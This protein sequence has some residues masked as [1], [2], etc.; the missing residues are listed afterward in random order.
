MG[1]MDET[2]SLAAPADVLSTGTLGR[3]YVLGGLLG[4]GGMADVYRAHDALLDRAVAV[5][6]FRHDTNIGDEHVRRQSEMQLLASLHHPG[7]VVIFDAGTDESDPAVPRSYLVM[8]L[9]DGATLGKLTAG[10]A[11]QPRDVATIGSQ[12][13]EALAYVHAR[14]IVHRDI[15][16]A[17]ILL[18]AP[19]RSDSGQVTAK[20]TDFGVARLLDGT[21]LTMHGMTVGTANYLSP[22]QATGQDVSPASDIYSFGLVLLECLTGRLAYPGYGIEAAVARL[23]R[24]PSIPEDLDPRWSQLLAK[25]TS[26]TPADRPTAIQVSSTLRE[27]VD[28]DAGS[29]DS[30]LTIVLQAAATGE[31]DPPPG[32]SR[33]RKLP[34]APSRRA[35]GRPIAS[36][37]QRQRRRRRRR[38]VLIVLAVALAVALILAVASTQIHSASTLRPAPSYPSVPGQLG[39]DLHNLQRSVQ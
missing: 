16:P 39:T 27:L 17:N 7:L 4:H 9:V 24:S 3:R 6:L 22:E 19:G 25:M 20:L 13:A 30:Q 12:L 26:T 8:E 32:T 2:A 11:M 21:R 10:G 14:G 15:K 29:P 38:S 5:K 37:R 36:W 28:N 35:A 1:L 18:T 31:L 33:T 34:A 23:H